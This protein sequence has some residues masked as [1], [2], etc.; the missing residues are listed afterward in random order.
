MYPV[1][2]RPS[3][4]QHIPMDTFQKG[5]IHLQ[6]ASD[7]QQTD[8]KQ[9]SPASPSFCRKLSIKLLPSFHIAALPRLADSVSTF[10]SDPK[11]WL[12][13]LDYRIVR[14]RKLMWKIGHQ[15]GSSM[16]GSRWYHRSSFAITSQFWYYSTIL[17]LIH[18]I[19]VATTQNKSS[20]VGTEENYRLVEKYV[21][22][23]HALRSGARLSRNFISRVWTLRKIK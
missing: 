2:D 11:G 22:Q 21:P 16:R 13:C 12:N 9:H 6:N 5:S 23:P 10:I 3:E 20:Y 4:A 15:D 18:L 8:F 17:S 19:V 14:I 7:F 1:S